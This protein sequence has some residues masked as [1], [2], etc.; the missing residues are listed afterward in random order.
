MKRADHHLDLLE[1]VPSFYSN[2]Q[3]RLKVSN[4]R[5]RQA[6]PL[7]GLTSYPQLRK[8]SLIGA[9]RDSKPKEES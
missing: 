3:V 5:S 2:P 8:V 4:R 1:R 6:L 9:R 7:S